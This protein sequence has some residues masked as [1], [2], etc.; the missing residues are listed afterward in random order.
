MAAHFP[1]KVDH[2]QVDRL[3]GGFM[4][5]FGVIIIAERILLPHI[6]C[7]NPKDIFA[8]LA[9][10]AVLFISVGGIYLL[11]GIL[12]KSQHG[13]RR[14]KHANHASRAGK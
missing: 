10:V 5:V 9:L 2:A 6:S 8:Q 13:K 14:E 7:S 3:R 1:F 12:L 4:I 11:R